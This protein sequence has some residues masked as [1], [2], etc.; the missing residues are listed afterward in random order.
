MSAEDTHHGRRNIRGG[1]HPRYS[2]MSDAGGHRQANLI[3]VEH[4]A[5]VHARCSS[6][7][8]IAPGSRIYV[9]QFVLGIARI[10]LI[11]QFDQAIVVDGMQ[12]PLRQLLQNRNLDCLD[13]GARPS[14]LERM[15]APA[16]NHHLAD[17]LSIA[18]KSAIGELLPAAA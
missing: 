4:V 6:Q 9:E 12:E 15:L 8:V 17:G 3:G 7:T 2:R 13:E 18:E 1:A 10:E 11:L 14:E 5:E 16:P